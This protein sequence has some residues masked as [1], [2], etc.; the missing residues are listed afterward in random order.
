MQMKFFV[1]MLLLVSAFVVTCLPKDT[2]KNKASASGESQK[3]AQTTP[4]GNG[5]QRGSQGGHL[6]SHA[7]HITNIVR[8]ALS[9]PGI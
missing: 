5:G 7:T 8:S 6:A 9:I 1:L 4:S 3:N 2:S